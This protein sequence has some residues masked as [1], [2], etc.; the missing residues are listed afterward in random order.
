MSRNGIATARDPEGQSRIMVRMPG[1]LFNAI[2]AAAND[3]S[4]GMSAEIAHRLRESLEDRRPAVAI[5]DQYAANM[6]LDR[7]ARMTA[8]AF[9]LGLARKARLRDITVAEALDDRDCYISGMVAALQHIWQ[10]SPAE[11]RS[12]AALR[13]AMLKALPHG[14]EE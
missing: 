14:V 8:A 9:A 12:D 6:E 4:R 2:N 5:D 13:E 11:N 10:D 3:S 7:V 1:E